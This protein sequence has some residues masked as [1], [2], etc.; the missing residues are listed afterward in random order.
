MK[1]LLIIL[2]CFTIILLSQTSSHELQFSSSALSYVEMPNTSL[3]IANKNAFS[4]SGWVYPEIDNSHNGLFGFR[5]NTNADFTYFLDEPL[6]SPIWP[7]RFVALSIGPATS[8]GKKA[9]K[10]EKY[11]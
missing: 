9:T 6:K 11:Q 2:L 7:N 3:L 8:C 10:F 5:N 1:K 4:I